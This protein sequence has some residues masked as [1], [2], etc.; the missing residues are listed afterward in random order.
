MP[1]GQF[2][3]LKIIE[4]HMPTAETIN[5][6]FEN[7]PCLEEAK[8]ILFIKYNLKR[9]VLL[10][11]LLFQLFSDSRHLYWNTQVFERPSF[12]MCNS[13]KR[14]EISFN[15]DHQIVRFNII[16]LIL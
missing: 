12:I 13:L 4:L 7:C 5:W 2:T 9:N 6:F 11:K 3:K 8:V 15:D 16:L 10:Y 14:L 1:V